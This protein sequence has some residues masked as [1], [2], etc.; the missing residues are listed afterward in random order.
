[1]EVDL[2]KLQSLGQSFLLDGNQSK[3]L[4][5]NSKIWIVTK[6]QLNIFYVALDLDQYENRRHYVE[7]KSAMDFVVGSMIKKNHKT[8]GLLAVGTQDTE[9]LEIEIEGFMAFINDSDVKDIIASYYGKAV[10]DFDLALLQEWQSEHLEAIGLA[11]DLALQ[12]ERAQA[13]KTMVKD[14][15]LFKEALKKL[16]TITV[17]LQE[18]YSL[19]SED[20]FKYATCKKVCDYN[21]IDIA[22]YEKL[23]G[24]IDSSNMLEEVG[25]LSRFRI[26]RI[27]LNCKWWEKDV[28]AFVAI[29]D[30]S[31]DIVAVIPS[32][33]KSYRVYNF[34]KKSSKNVDEEVAKSLCLYGYYFYRP[35]P[36]KVLSLKD[37]L[38]F[39]IEHCWKR[40]FLTLLMM[41]VLGGLVGLAV[42]I[43]TG[44]I[45][46]SVIP[47]NETMQ[48]VQIGFFLVAFTFSSVL[49]E[50][51]KS[52]ALLRIEGKVDQSLQ[53]AVWDRL[54]SL[55]VNFFDNYD[56]GDLAMRSLS[57]EQIRGILS[58]VLVSSVVAGVFSVFYLILMFTYSV[59]LATIA[60]T[61]TLFIVMVSIFLGWK[62][63]K[64]EQELVA[65]KNKNAGV[66]FQLIS[67]VQKFKIA[68]AESR[69]FGRWSDGFEY[70]RQIN[71]KKQQV[72]NISST[73]NT[74][75]ETMLLIIVF[76]V[77]GT[78]VE[79]QL[80]AGQFLGFN[81]AFI[82]LMHAM[83][84]LSEA[85]MKVNIIKP[86][87][88]KSK[89]ILE[90]LP[91]YD[92]SKEEIG[93]LDGEIE[94]RHVH[95][96]YENS[97]EDVLKDVTLKIKSGEYVALV[98]PSGSGKST[99]FRN[100][101]GFEK[102]YS[103]RIFYDEKDMSKYDIRSIRKQL[104][105]VLQNGQVMAGDLYTNI[106]G[107]NS[108]LTMDDAWRAA[109]MAGLDH[110]IEEMPMGLNTIVSE[111]AS[112][113]SGGQRQRLMIA[114]AVVNKP[115]ILYFDEATSALDNKTQKIVSD[116]LDVLNIT[117]VVIAHRLSTIR[118]CDRIIV[119]D[120]GQIVEEGAY[121]ALMEKRGLFYKLAMRQM[122]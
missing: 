84:S 28:G 105:V 35:F 75:V 60:T 18:D 12:E 104:G 99:L 73:F 54:M 82:L 49:F 78:K 41:S 58:G 85:I 106:I 61:M 55:P 63:L 77:M 79:N 47:E 29:E 65:V 72:A 114:R 14:T 40:D 76:Y 33:S 100:L 50:L 70:S 68:G 44:I 32:D 97:T 62:Q 56:S 121:E 19:E 24:I 27:K 22:P 17:P 8:Y 96:S 13:E 113:L 115:K 16:V 36:E 90:T 3:T 42:P 46:D 9:L 45:F 91:E 1:M 120:K 111:G 117:R 30:L 86:L 94:V 21:N 34:K 64:Y 11:C 52:F 101:I 98:G 74:M 31:K 38:T 5:D 67:S 66:L 57:I 25:R 7:S 83:L 69:A 39:G 109:R 108:R 51:T 122:A 81:A 6:G 71:Y 102:P 48:L 4:V 110:D 23:A 20:S 15:V 43:A 116:S 87:Y 103:G 59:P 89:P 26:R 107:A 119:M 118:N 2:K 10:K 80:Q 92:E 112:T 53:S 93:C 88:D 95:F 37:I